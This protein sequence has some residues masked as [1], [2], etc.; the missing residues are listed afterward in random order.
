MAVI[1]ISINEISQTTT[2]TATDRISKCTI[3]C[4]PSGAAAGLLNQFIGVSTPSDFATK[5]PT[6]PEVV[7][8]SVKMFFANNS[9]GLL[10]VY[11]CSDS[12]ITGTTQADLKNHL[13]KGVSLL[14][15]RTDIDLSLCI[16]PEIGTFTAQADRTAI[17]SV[18]QTMCEK[19]DWLFFLNA[20]VDTDT[21]AKAI[22][23][24]AL[25]SSPLGHSSFYYGRIV[26][27]DSKIVPV[28]VAA[29]AIALKRDRIEPYS[30]PAGAKYPVQGI[31]DLVNYVDNMT[32]YNDL[33]S[34]QIN[35]L[36]KVPRY[37]TCLWGAQTLSTDTK[38]SLI[39]TRIAV[40]V[41]SFRLESSLIPILFA[42]SDPQGRTNREV[43]RIIISLMTNLWLEGALSGATPE[44]AFKIED[45]LVPADPT[46]QQQG[47]QTTTTPTTANRQ[48]VGDIARSLKKVQKKIYARFVEH[49]S[50]IEIGVFVVDL[51]PT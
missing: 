42:A 8:Q 30:P 5:Y 49:V 6:A 3:I 27:N 45:V 38:F 19:F 17:Y 18:I 39:N 7:L 12:T 48:V 35:V 15:L 11:A 23:E 24:R 13:L 31:K 22:A 9:D 41:A 28:S 44:D 10:N 4:T 29:A 32:D 46:Q 33:K 37:G 36:Q 16:C 47:Q 43:D 34:Q 40:S 25:Y 20:A 2:A 21:K 51:L 1:G 50:Q 14:I 26:D